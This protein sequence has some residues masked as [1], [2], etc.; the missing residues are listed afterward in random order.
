MLGH[1]AT[2]QSIAA[3]Q[4]EHGTTGRDDHLL[5]KAH[6]MI[7]R[8]IP[9]PLPAG[10]AKHAARPAATGTASTASRPSHA[11]QRAA[12]A[13]GLADAARNIKTIAQPR[14]RCFSKRHRPL[15]DRHDA[16]RQVPRNPPGKRCLDR[17]RKQRKPRRDIAGTI[18][19]IFGQQARSAQHWQLPVGRKLYVA[20][21]FL[22]QIRITT[23][24]NCDE[25]ALPGCEIV[26]RHVECLRL[27]IAELRKA[28]RCVTDDIARLEAEPPGRRPSKP[29]T[30]VG[31]L[32]KIGQVV[33]AGAKVQRDVTN[34]I[35]KT[36]APTG[37]R[38]G[39]IH[40][41]ERT[42]PGQVRC[43]ASTA[44][45]AA[46]DVRPVVAGL[47]R[48][49]ERTCRQTKRPTGKR[50]QACQPLCV[51]DR[52]VRPG[53]RKPIYQ[54]L[55]FA[56]D[57]IG[58]CGELPLPEISVERG[59][60]GQVGG[61]ADPLEWSGERIQ[62]RPAA[63]FGAGGVA[64]KAEQPALAILAQTGRPTDIEPKIARI[65]DQGAV[66]GRIRAG[67]Y[68][69]AGLNNAALAFIERGR[70]VGR[71]RHAEPVISV[72]LEKRAFQHQGRIPATCRQTELDFGRTV[73][74]IV[75]EDEIHHAAVGR[76][77][78][79]Q[80]HL[81]GQHLDLADRL[82]REIAHF[83]KVGN[84]L[85]VDQDHRNAIAPAPA[86]TRLRGQCSQQIGDRSRAIGRDLGF[87]QRHDRGL[88]YIERPAQSR[89]DNQYLIYFRL[90]ICRVSLQCVICRLSLRSICRSTEQGKGKCRIAKHVTEILQLSGQS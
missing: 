15:V 48:H 85:A 6:G 78:E 79:A 76:I 37:Q 32:A 40:A 9:P 80:C 86:R 2:G 14:S 72:Y 35:Q 88:R 49:A 26:E 51:A 71:S 67:C 41:G 34:R 8:N 83:A 46:V 56:M 58:G 19:E 27:R 68:G 29:G 23:P 82:G 1:A 57:C 90:W 16:P 5:G 21:A 69:K 54:G 52:H 18:A 77:A 33:V 60:A 24:D 20:L 36:F 44:G 64:V 59:P 28:G 65:R 12:T 70:V 66:I 45:V 31:Q 10:A 38:Q 62:A 87:I 55:V 42:A 81:F 84:A 75:L 3:Q 73:A 47:N 22:D 30:P 7:E 39:E 50:S 74:E 43:A 4:V 13:A 89:G 17:W 63:A 53:P 11:A 61:A 25:D